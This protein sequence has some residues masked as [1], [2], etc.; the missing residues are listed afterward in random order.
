V[1][2]KGS[3]FQPGD[4]YHADSDH[5]FVAEWKK[6]DSEDGGGS[7]PGDDDKPSSP[8][9]SDAG[10]KGGTS[11]PGPGSS[12]K[13]AQAGSN[14]SKLP[15]TGDHANPNRSL[16]LLLASSGTIAAA[17]VRKRKSEL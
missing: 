17:I 4:A 8:D 7:T 5:A 11:T 3:E 10:N 1:C 13:N 9:D 6:N 2:W 15:E 12:R 14:P 16:L